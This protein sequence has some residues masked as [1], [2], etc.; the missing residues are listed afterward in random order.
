MFFTDSVVA[1][2]TSPAAHIVVVSDPNGNHDSGY[3]PSNVEDTL[4]GTSTPPG[5]PRQASSG[6]DTAGGDSN[7]PVRG[8]AAKIKSNI[9]K[10]NGVDGSPKKEPLR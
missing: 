3:A 8:V 10:R 5:S 9:S 4:A 2:I 6:T 7:V 1:Q